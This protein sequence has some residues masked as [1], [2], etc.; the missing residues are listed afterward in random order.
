MRP[1]E[2][3]LATKPGSPI[4]TTNSAGKP[5]RRCPTAPLVTRTGHALIASP[6]PEQPQLPVSA[7]E[8][9]PR[10]RISTHERS[11]DDMRANLRSV[12][13]PA[14]VVAGIVRERHVTRLNEP[15]VRPRGILHRGP[16]G[17]IAELPRGMADWVASVRLGGRSRT[18]LR[19]GERQ[20][21]DR[22]E[23][24][25]RSHSSAHNR[26]FSRKGTRLS[27]LYAPECET[28]YVDSLTG[29][30]EESPGQYGTLKALYSAATSQSGPISRK[31]SSGK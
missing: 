8:P 10:G 26:S 24:S 2:A 31:R 27:R 23:A 13:D 6:R 9:L 22:H 15:L 28:G 25:E 11:L 3:Q 12:I 7:E 19:S 21:G 29:H 17:V 20:R 18:A 1:T 30:R 14:V 16:R 5:R 4:A